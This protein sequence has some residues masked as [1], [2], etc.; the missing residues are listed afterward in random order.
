[1]RINDLRL[2]TKLW[3]LVLSVLSAVTAVAVLDSVTVH[4]SNEQAIER[5]RRADDLITE[6]TQWRTISQRNTERTLATFLARDADHVKFFSERMKAGIA[7]STELQKLIIDTAV[8]ERDKAQVQKMVDL[9][10]ALV[11]AIKQV[12]AV[13]EAGDPAAVQPA[14][15]KVF[16]PALATYDAAQA[17]MVSLQLQERDEAL[18]DA[19]AQQRHTLV[20]SIVGLAAVL[21][22]ALFATSL[23]LRSIVRPL[24][25][26]V[27]AAEAIATG[28]LRNRL[29]TERADEVGRLMQ[30][31]GKMGEQL[32]RLV[33]EVRDGVSSVDTASAEIATGNQ[34]LSMRTEQTASHLQQTA[35]SLEQ[36]TVT[37][38]QSADNAGHADQ[39][40]TR[41]QAAATRSGEAVGEVVGRMDEISASSRQIAEITSV[42]DGIAFQTNILALNAA[43]EAARAGEQ[44]RGFAVVAGEVR[45]LAQRSGEAAREIRQLIARS[46]ETVEAGSRQVGVAKS[47]IDEVVT[48]MGQVAS[49]IAD[50]SHATNEQRE[51]IVQVNQAVTE[52]DQMTQQNAALVEE[53]AAAASSL[54]DQSKRLAETVSVFRTG[55]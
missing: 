52:I 32:R 11:A 39:L 54:R 14:I 50:L 22:G 29:Q 47:V 30:A 15:D 46:V 49:L 25:E 53:A 55:D 40:A 43:V 7:E 21:A 41:A 45:T 42:I 35:S 3:G 12:T 18:A 27:A 28:D 9:R 31:V 20:L 13:K 10:K 37:I 24:D 19:Q 2:S 6:V 51:G 48:G 16:M 4:H 23:L 8:S 1:M 33:H 36:V 34:D 17:E 44:G 38:R 5:L 26:T